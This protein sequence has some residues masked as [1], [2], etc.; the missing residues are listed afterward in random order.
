[1]SVG[2]LEKRLIIAKNT[3]RRLQLHGVIFI[4]EYIINDFI[5]I[6]NEYHWLS[7]KQLF[8]KG[9]KIS[10]VTASP[11]PQ[12]VLKVFVHKSHPEK[13]RKQYSTRVFK[14]SFAILNEDRMC[15]AS[16]F[17]SRISRSGAC[18]INE[19]IGRH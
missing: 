10:L 5:G 11:T 2:F 9:T 14:Y 13:Y 1:V 18:L 15:S 4:M 16:I 6:K 12:T 7:T 19:K 8:R 3:K 17:V